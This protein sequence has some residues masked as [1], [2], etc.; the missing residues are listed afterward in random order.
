MENIQ[1]G[2]G[3]LQ[4]PDTSDSLVQE[5]YGEQNFRLIGEYVAI[6]V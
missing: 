6:N 4:R 3:R 1:F 5:M 2:A